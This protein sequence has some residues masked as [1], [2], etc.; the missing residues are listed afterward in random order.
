MGEIDPEYD[1]LPVHSRTYEVIAD[2]VDTLFRVNEQL[3]D[4]A[5]EWA[6][7]AYNKVESKIDSWFAPDRT[8]E[9]MDYHGNPARILEKQSFDGGYIIEVHE[10]EETYKD[11]ASRDLVNQKFEDGKTSEDIDL[12]LLEYEE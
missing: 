5:D 10:E 4:T 9:W 3:E 2:K 8:G 6:L 11:L 1:N 12:N 7:K